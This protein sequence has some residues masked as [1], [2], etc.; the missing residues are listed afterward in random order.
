MRLS[1][2][3]A[4]PWFRKD[5]LSRFLLQLCCYHRST[6]KEQVASLLLEDSK[7]RP[8][9]VRNALMSQAI[10]LF[11]LCEAVYGNDFAAS[12][13]AQDA[14]AD[15]EAG[16][17]CS[18]DLVEFS[19]SLA[20]DGTVGDSIQLD[21]RLPTQNSR[22]PVVSFRAAFLTRSQHAAVCDATLSKPIEDLL[23]TIQQIK[24]AVQS[25][26]DAAAIPAAEPLQTAPETAPLFR[27]CS[28]LLEAIDVL[29]GPGTASF[30][31]SVH[32]GE[33]RRHCEL[34]ERLWHYRLRSGGQ[35][36]FL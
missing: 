5:S 34:G 23:E 30:S 32:E 9:V 11:R 20:L 28:K 22:Q 2:P 7:L 15:F 36:V 8:E 19:L 13:Q 12:D 17:S 35:V 24:D 14:I 27:V 6:E 25:L 29:L 1:N 18:L 10:E 3:S 16:Q 26:V 31:I 33:T 4:A 21:V